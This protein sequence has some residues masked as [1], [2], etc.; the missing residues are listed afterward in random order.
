MG[1]LFSRGIH[2]A[3]CACLVSNVFS[4]A[5]WSV[6]QDRN[7]WM[8]ESIVSLARNNTHAHSFSVSDMSLSSE[9]SKSL[10]GHHFI[11]GVATA[12]ERERYA[13]NAMPLHN[14]A[15]CRR[16]GSESLYPTLRRGQHSDDPVCSL[17]NCNVVYIVW[18]FLLRICR[19]L[20]WGGIIVEGSTDAA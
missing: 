1:S 16:Q 9:R 18:T 14:T 2:C 17:G 15:G 7:T 10:V 12:R 4:T 19:R 5:K 3:I 13:E 11:C 6:A 8:C 20:M